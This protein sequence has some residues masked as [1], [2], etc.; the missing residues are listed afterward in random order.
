MIPAVIAGYLV[1]VL[2][3]GVV[4]HRYFTGSSEDYFLAGRSIGPF[5]LLMSLF[6]THMTAFALLGA[7]GESYRSGIGVFALMASSSALVVP[8]VVL[9]LGTRMW[10][11]GKRNGYLTQVQFFRERWQSDGLGLALFALLTLFLIPYLLLGVM[12]GGITLNQITG[13]LIAEWV[14]SL[15]VCLVVLAYVTYSGLRATAW[16]NTFQTLVFMTLGVVAFLIIVRQVGG[17]VT[18]WD[19]LGRQSP[20]LLQIGHGIPAAKMLTYMLVPLSVGM[21]PHI[22]MHWLSARRVETFRLTIVFFPICIAIVWVPT[23]VIG[24]L[25]R[26]DF[27]QL[28]GPAASS[29]LVKMIELHAPELLAGLLA[30]GVFAAIMSSLDS[31]VLALGTMFTQDIVRR[32]GFQGRMS[33]RTQV[34][35]GRCFVVLIL[36]VVFLLSLVTPPSIFAIGVW[37]FSGFAAL[38]PVLVAALFWKRSTKQG[39]YLA[40]AVVAVLWLLFFIDGWGVPDYTVSGTGIMPV[41]VLMTASSLAMVLGSLWSRPPEPAVLRRFFD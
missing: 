34:L 4:S 20:E 12:A 3:I 35:A 17:L 23:V 27:P 38:L 1:L 9:F 41:A 21:F 32:Y 28:S 29:I 24:V 30:A 14:G 26:L 19:T 5:L 40:L 11:V 31:Q 8:V 6:G 39:A 18:A 36:V 13:G 15:A 37:S 2:L 10:Q 22:F 7:S 33:E 16:A 25:G